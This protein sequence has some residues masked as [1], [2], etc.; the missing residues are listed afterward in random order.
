MSGGL[1]VET[2]SYDGERST[3]GRVETDRTPLTV[4]LALAALAAIQLIHHYLHL[5][6]TLATHFGF[7]GQAD[8]WTDKPS[9]FIIYGIVE[10]AIVVGAF[11]IARFA[12]RFPT[13]ALNIPNRDYWLEPERRP[14][15]LKFIWSQVLWIE[16]ATLAFLIA[17]AEI[18]FRANLSP[19]PSELPEEFVVVLV[20]FV[21]VM[22]WLSLRIVRRFR[23]PR[24]E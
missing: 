1:N 10:L 11:L 23:G 17:I 21:V 24:T 9:F 19:A 4:L 15:S 20:V 22:A 12:A 2:G 16:A 13:G 3:G 5:P 6:G 14:V 18:I 7:G 8:G